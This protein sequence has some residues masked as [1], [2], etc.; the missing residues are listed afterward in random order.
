MTDKINDREIYRRL[1]EN[2][3][4]Q[5][6]IG[7]NF[8]ITKKGPL[9]LWDPEAQDLLGII[10]KAFEDAKLTPNGMKILKEKKMNSELVLLD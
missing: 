3:N 8:G 2:P 9:S 4:Q 5:W 7:M 10:T 1:S 6:A